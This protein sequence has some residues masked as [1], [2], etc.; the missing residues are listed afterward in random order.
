MK[1]KIFIKAIL[2]TA[3]LNNSCAL[4]AEYVRKDAP[5]ETP[6]KDTPTQQ[7]RMARPAPLVAPKQPSQAQSK[8]P[9]SSPQVTTKQPQIESTAESRKLDAAVASVSDPLTVREAAKKREEADQST[10]YLPGT[11]I[12]VPELSLPTGFKPKPLETARPI[13]AKPLSGE[14]TGTQIRESEESIKK[15]TASLIE[16]GLSSSE[17]DFLMKMS[18][19]DRAETIKKLE[20]NQTLKP[21]QPK[22]VVETQRPIAEP[23]TTPK[24][25]TQPDR[26]AEEATRRQTEAR[27]SQAKKAATEPV[28]TSKPVVQ[29]LIQ[30][31]DA[32]VSRQIEE[33]ARTK[34]VLNLSP[35][36][37]ELAASLGDRAIDMVTKMSPAEI[38]A[39]SPEQRLKL[40]EIIKSR[41]LMINAAK[42]SIDRQNELRENFLKNPANKGK[43]FPETEESMRKQTQEQF[44]FSPDG[45]RAE[46]ASEAAERSNK[47]LQLLGT[48][49]DL[50][51]NVLTQIRTQISELSKKKKLTKS[52]KAMLKEAT[53]KYISNYFSIPIAD[54]PET[55]KRQIDAEFSQ[56]IKQNPREAKAILKIK[57]QQQNALL[58]KIKAIEK[59]KA[60]FFKSSAGKKIL[61]D[62]NILATQLNAVQDKIDSIDQKMSQQKKDAARDQFMPEKKR[63]QAEMDKLNSVLTPPKDNFK[64]SS[65][66]AKQSELQRQV[67]SIQIYLKPKK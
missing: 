11:G 34:E 64:L 30:I 19:T 35:E 21:A 7:G 61:A 45:K 63:I 25:V 67:R 50:R 12:R 5:E 17:A 1:Y 42:M 47:A 28:T 10:R 15:Q 40:F 54:T 56:F 53:N 51:V 66:K 33:I 57:Q 38:N 60:K 22:P 58:K 41:G 59:Q 6:K 32:E 37:K 48:E 43:P 27:E 49:V 46:A 13:T 26:E 36:Q 65:L 9:T 2:T 44:A 23:A 18:P 24:P 20:E 4:V 3:L 31:A 29:P 52:E 8:L 39:L 62:M 55:K 16:R 14:Q